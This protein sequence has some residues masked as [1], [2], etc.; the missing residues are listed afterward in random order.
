VIDRQ[1]HLLCIQPDFDGD[2][3]QDINRGSVYVGLAGFTE[4]AIVHRDAESLQ[5]TL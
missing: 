5:E 1:H 4:A 2:G 3:L